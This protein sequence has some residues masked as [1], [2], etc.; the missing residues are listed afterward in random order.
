MISNETSNTQSE[1]T[2]TETE[3]VTKNNDQFLEI[4][5]QIDSLKNE[6]KILNEKTLF[7]KDKEELNLL[8]ETFISWSKRSDVNCYAKIFEYDNIFVKLFWLFILIASM[9]VTAWIV[10]WNVVAYLDYGVVSQIG[11]VYEIPTE[12]PAVTLCDNNPFTSSTGRSLINQPSG[13]SQTQL[14]NAIRLAEMKASDPSYGD[15][16]RKQLGLSITQVNCSYNSTDC[17]NDL[18]WYWHYSYGNCFQFNVGLNW[19]SNYINT[20]MATYHT[21]GGR[22]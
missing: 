15:A 14:I 2:E 13:T 7:Q 20:K 8:K 4:H 5:D 18:H 6:I 10:S 9:S 11:D 19:T 3:E 1:T 17:K 16:N 12:F 21:Y 22:Y